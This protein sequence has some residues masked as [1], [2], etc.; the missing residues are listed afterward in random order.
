MTNANDN[1]NTALITRQARK[2]TQ[3]YPNFLNN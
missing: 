3:Y 1:W 2:S